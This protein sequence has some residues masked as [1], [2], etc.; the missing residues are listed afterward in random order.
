MQ[1]INK[2]IVHYNQVNGISNLP[3]VH[4]YGV[5]KDERTMTDSKVEHKWDQWREKERSR[6]LHLS[7]DMR[8]VLG[9]AI[10]KYFNS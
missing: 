8:M 2:T 7:N 5:D 6:K 1:Q 4:K 3:H 9:R 10:N